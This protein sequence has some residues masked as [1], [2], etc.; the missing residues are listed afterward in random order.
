MCYIYTSESK[1]YMYGTYHTRYIYNCIVCLTGR[2]AIY[3]PVAYALRKIYLAYSATLFRNI[4]RI[5]QKL[6]HLKYFIL[7]CF[8]ILLPISKEL[9]AKQRGINLHN[10]PLMVLKTRKVRRIFLDSQIL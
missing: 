10:M 8:F 3:L 4:D 9:I 7:I 5:S 1:S 6:L 2:D